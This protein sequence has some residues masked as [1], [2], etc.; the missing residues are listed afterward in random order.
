MSELGAR[1]NRG[2]VTHTRGFGV[3]SGVFRRSE[4][5]FWALPTLGRIGGFLGMG[6]PSVGKCV[7]GMKR[8]ICR[9]SPLECGKIRGE[10]MIGLEACVSGGSADTSSGIRGGHGA[11]GPRRGSAGVGSGAGAMA[12][13]GGWGGAASVTA[14]G[15]GVNG[16]TGAE[17]ADQG[18]VYDC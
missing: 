15:V 3:G 2:A 6:L 10:I 13:W 5:F 4:A 1:K 8:R 18:V 9:G 11:V 14:I 16:D 7:F 12:A 17:E